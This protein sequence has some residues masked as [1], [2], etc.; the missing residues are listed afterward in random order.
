MPLAHRQRQLTHLP[1]PQGECF[2]FDRHK[3]KQFTNF[4]RNLQPRFPTF[5][6]HAMQAAY[7]EGPNHWLRPEIT[8]VDL[9]AGLSSTAAMPRWSCEQP[10]KRKRG[11]TC[12]KTNQQL[13][14]PPK[15]H[16][17]SLQISTL[18]DSS[19]V[20]LSK[21]LC[22]SPGPNQS[23]SSLGHTGRSK[24]LTRTGLSTGPDMTAL[25]V[26][27]Q[28]M[29]Q[30]LGFG[31]PVPNHQRYSE[32]GTLPCMVSSAFFSEGHTDIQPE[33]V[34]ATF[35]PLAINLTELPVQGST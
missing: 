12:E 19:R 4:I 6:S 7:T 24:E 16:L 21:M 15:R 33:A 13:H 1:S 25:T 22:S 2:D 28:T 17:R 18:H 20:D 31:I 34:F 30:P 8:E 29:G 35:Y 10:P 27:P 11:N 5:G 3:T 26:E 14:R 9:L 32:A 23:N